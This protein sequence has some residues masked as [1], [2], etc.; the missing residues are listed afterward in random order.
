VT[1]ANCSSCPESGLR[2]CQGDITIRI[3]K[4]VFQKSIDR[5]FMMRLKEKTD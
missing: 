1:L 4:A 3:V 2:S 5:E